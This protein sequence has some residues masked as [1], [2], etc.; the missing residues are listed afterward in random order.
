MD[1]SQS[2][3]DWGLKQREWPWS[4]WLVGW[5]KAHMSRWR[6]G[7]RGRV[8]RGGF[9]CA[10]GMGRRMLLWWFSCFTWKARVEGI[11][12]R[13]GTCAIVF[14]N[15]GFL[16]LCSSKETTDRIQSQ[17]TPLIHHILWLLI[18]QVLKTKS[19]TLYPHRW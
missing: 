10:C 11:G 17:E 2:N 9:I 13:L 7:V 8:R 15:M 4:L 14:F 19:Y 1:D 3:R 18:P 6:N 16:L 5:L 12:C